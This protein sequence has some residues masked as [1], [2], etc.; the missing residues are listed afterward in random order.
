M[1]DE[2]TA[3]DH[4]Q[5]TGPWR[6]TAD[7]ASVFDDMLRRSIPQHD[8][9]RA[10]VFELGSRFVRPQTT[11]LDLGCSRGEALDPFVRRFGAHNRFV[12]VD[13]S[14]PMLDAARARF[15][16]YMRTNVVAIAE[17]DLRHDYPREHA[18]LTLAVLTLQFVPLEYRA[19]LVRRMYEQTLPGGACIVVEKVLGDSPRIDTLL[20]DEYLSLKRAHGYSADEIARKRLALEGVLVPLTAHW[21]VEQ[22]RH[23]GFADVDC[24][25]R[26]LN[27][28][29]WLAVRA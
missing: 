26:W 5:Q 29:G 17:C 2:T 23:A 11:V 18:S 19:T 24:F 27:F 8:D 21:N 4:V 7:V 20:V 6:F 12:G 28:A 13:V 9:M 22:L 16:G 1:S 10:L 14:G 3:V 15:E 25:W